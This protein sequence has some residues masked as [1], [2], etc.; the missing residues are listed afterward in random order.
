MAG[1]ARRRKQIKCKPYI[2]TTAEAK[3]RGL[4]RD[5]FWR[6]PEQPKSALLEPLPLRQ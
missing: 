6:K 2:M 3:R 1:K 4:P 5:Y